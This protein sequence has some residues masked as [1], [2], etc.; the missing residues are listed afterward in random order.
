MVDAVGIFRGTFFCAMIWL[1]GMYK[2]TDGR[3][4]G[5]EVKGLKKIWKNMFCV[6]VII[7]VCVGYLF[8]RGDIG[9]QR[10]GIE[11]D[12]RRNSH[13]QQDWTVVQD[14]SDHMAALIAYDDTDCRYAL[15]VNRPNLSFGY[16]FRGGGA[17]SEIKNGIAEVMVEEYEER[18]IFSMNQQKTV[19]VKVDYGNEVREIALDKE[20]PFV[21]ILPRNCGNVTFYDETGNVVETVKRKW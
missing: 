5:K 3:W 7:C 20:K 21:M 14:V 9:V 4:N 8:C 15:Y 2:N 6:L 17:A 12:F 16:F 19:C 18:A 11:K 1:K 10:S 13:I